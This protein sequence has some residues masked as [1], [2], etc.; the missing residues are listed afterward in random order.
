MIHLVTGSVRT[1]AE[2]SELISLPV[3]TVLISGSG[4]LRIDGTEEVTS[5]IGRPLCLCVPMP[6]L[7]SGWGWVAEAH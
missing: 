2:V 3:A 4:D 5:G 6:P 1:K 7:D